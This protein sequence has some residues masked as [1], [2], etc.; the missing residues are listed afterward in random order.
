[1]RKHSLTDWIY[2]VLLSLM[3][4]TSFLFTK[5]AVEHIPPATVVTARLGLAA[6][7][8]VAV[9]LRRGW[10]LSHAPR[11]W[12][13]LLV[14]SLLGNTVPFFLIAWG[15]QSIDSA[16]AAM[17]LASMPLVTLVLAHYFVEGEPLTTGKALGF[18]IGLLGIVILVG[19]DAV[20]GFG[21]DRVAI[22]SQLAIMVAAL[23]YSINAVLARRLP[24][25]DAT[26][27]TTATITLAAL[28][29]LPFGAGEGAAAAAHLTAASAFSLAWLGIVSTA[30]ATILYFRIIASAGPTFLSL[31]N[32]LIPPI[33]IVVGAAVLGERPSARAIAA[34]AVILLGIATSQWSSS[35]AEPLTRP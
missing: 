7:V 34:L 33:A 16:L 25:G 22:L 32:Y 30:L 13:H 11:L 28:T 24:P 14:L 29:I 9:M 8:L 5:I 18:T 4:G 17:L 23:C 26:A 15:Q 31:I 19:P 2:L 12:L 6:V 35:S 3:W 20:R 21:G 1:M 27:H 10:P